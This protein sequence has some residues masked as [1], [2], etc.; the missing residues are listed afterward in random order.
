LQGIGFGA[1]LARWT[2]MKKLALLLAMTSTLAVGCAPSE[3][4]DL[5]CQSEQCDE[6]SE[7]AGPMESAHFV[8]VESCD[9]IVGEAILGGGDVD[10][11]TALEQSKA[12]LIVA[13]DAVAAIIDSTAAAAGIEV[14]GT[15]AARLSAFRDTSLCGRLG[16]ASNPADKPPAQMC[17]LAWERMMAATID[18]FVA[19]E[20]ALKAPMGSD[21]LELN[22]TC[23]ETFNGAL[24][25]ASSSDEVYDAHMDL[26]DCVHS[27]TLGKMGYIAKGIIDNFPDRDANEVLGSM[28]IEMQR[29]LR[30]MTEV[31]VNLGAASGAA[32]SEEADLSAF[33]CEAQLKSRTGIM[34]NAYT[35]WLGLEE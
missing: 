18:E 35:E 33:M 23:F 28:S 17:E 16:E 5:A 19:F 34:I 32:T 24:A 8:E 15:M 4:S 30:A 29:T 27:R 6:P 13:D 21:G 14:E 31:C 11:F 26:A 7:P 25:A 2:S 12:C 20:G 3:E 10:F 9:E 1:A 22:A